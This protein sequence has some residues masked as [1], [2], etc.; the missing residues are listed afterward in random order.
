MTVKDHPIQLP[1]TGGEAGSARESN[2]Y[3]HLEAASWSKMLRSL[4]P[5]RKAMHDRGLA[6]NGCLGWQWGGMAS[7]PQLSQASA[8]TPSQGVGAH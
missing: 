2:F 3:D 8:S 4:R 6:D 5:G 1:F 7:P